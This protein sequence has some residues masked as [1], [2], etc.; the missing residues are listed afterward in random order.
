MALVLGL[1]LVS[2][3]YPAFILSA[4]QPAAVLKGKLHQSSRGGGIRQVLVV[5]QFSL[6]ITVAIVMVFI[7]QQV[8][9][10]VN[11][12]LGFQPSQVV[13]IPVNTSQTG[14]R[15]DAFKSQLQQHP[16]IKD[17]TYSTSLPGTW[18]PDNM[19]RIAGADKDQSSNVYFTS[20][21]YAHTLGLSLSRG[22][23]FS[24]QHPADTANAF[25]VNEAF[26]Q[27]YG[28][29]H[30]VGHQ[31]K[32]SNDQAYGT[33]IGVIKD[34]HYQGLQ[35]S[36]R[37]LVMAGF[38]SQGWAPRYAAIRVTSEDLPATLAFLKAQWRQIEPA[39]P[40]RYSFLD[41]NFARQYDTFTRLGETMLYATLLTV[42]IACLGL[43][44]L[45][46]FMAGQ[47]TREI[48][49][50]KVLGATEWEIVHL[51]GRKFV[52]LVSIACVLAMPP[53]FWIASKW[54]ADF[55]YRTSITALPFLMA[56]GVALLAAALTVSFRAYKAALADPVKSLRSE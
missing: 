15:I 41:D 27:Q 28:L 14:E 35:Q 29:K 31:M 21:G 17:V 26:V 55:A 30:P 51:L 4:Y 3:S 20:P 7:Y 8:Q 18:H 19:F 45:A 2:G 16:R 39:H 11:Q 1:G 47:R 46:S 22:R 49:I 37:P 50:R 44:G 53:A 54:L 6:A 23:F 25:V 43:F 56:A 12:Q 42:L 24:Y 52:Q 9:F 36:I 38:K 13:V 40:M 34:F 5:T 10:M 33:I 48:G 32:F